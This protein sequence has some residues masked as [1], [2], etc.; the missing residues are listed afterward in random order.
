MVDFDFLNTRTP[1]PTPCSRCAATFD[2]ISEEQQ[3]CTECQFE[4][5][6]PELAPQYWTW[7]RSG[8]ST[9]TAVATWPDKEPLPEPG[10]TITVHRRDGSSSEHTITETDGVLYDRSGRPRLHC[11][12]R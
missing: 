5:D 1:N 3:L 12:V 2:Q 8:S 6:H 7:T 4:S 10:D 11:R 9:W